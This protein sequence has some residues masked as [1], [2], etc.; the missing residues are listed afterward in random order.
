MYD[1]IS[2]LNRQIKVESFKPFKRLLFKTQVLAL[3]MS[4]ND[5]LMNRLT[6]SYLVKSGSE[7]IAESIKLNGI[8]VDYKF[9]L[10]VVSLLHDVGQAPFGHSGAYTISDVFKDLGLEEGFDDNNNNFVVIK[11]NGGFNFISDYELASLIK[12]PNKLYDSQK[13]KLLPIL[14]LAINQDIEYFSKLGISI[15]SKPTRTVSC[16][17]MD[18]ADRNA[19]VCNDL[20]DA[21]V[22]GF[23]TKKH[24]KKIIKKNYNSI[25]IREW[26][27]SVYSAIKMKDKSLIGFAFN[28][29]F[30]MLSMNYYLGE[31]LKLKPKS[32]ELIELRED[33]YLLEK[34][35]FIKNDKVVKITDE[36]CKLLKKY[37]KYVIE[38]EHYTSNTY[39]YLIKN[40]KTKNE[41]LTHIRDMIGECSDWFIFRESKKIGLVSK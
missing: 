11:K 22:H 13:E 19:Y 18:E 31:N 15:T 25:E 6:H 10:A 17:I 27:F 23:I 38:N 7:L 8:D 30:T 34:D 35:M 28:K 5:T 2:S 39:K 32:N 4:F 21:L 24:F 14:N 36:N 40:A 16:E 29:L 1:K 9:S 33:L 37:I 41:K 3:D 20:T 26:L 12:Y